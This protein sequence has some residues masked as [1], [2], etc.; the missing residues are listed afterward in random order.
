MQIAAT[1]VLVA[2]SC[3]DFRYGREIPGQ[4][5]NEEGVH[6]KIR[7]RSVR[8]K[9]AHTIGLLYYITYLYYLRQYGLIEF[10]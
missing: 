7:N 9:M 1:S 8:E 3:C 6:D 10:S 4:A 2:V 5:G